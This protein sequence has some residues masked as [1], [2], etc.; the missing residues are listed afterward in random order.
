MRIL[1]AGGNSYTGVHLIQRLETLYS[2]SISKVVITRKPTKLKG[3][4]EIIGDLND[5]N[6]L[7][8]VSGK[9]DC[10][11][12][13]AQSREYRNFPIGYRDMLQI[14]TMFPIFL[15][16]WAINKNVKKFFYFSTGNVYKETSSLL[17]EQSFT[18]PNSFYGASKLSTELFL[19]NYI[20]YFDVINLRIF[21]IYGPG[22]TGML[23]P[24]ILNSIINSKEII[25]ND[26][27]GLKITPI[28]IDDLVNVIIDLV[29]SEQTLPNTINI[30]GDE[31]VSIKDIVDIGSSFLGVSPKLLISN[32]SGKYLMADNSLLRKLV[33]RDF[34]NIKSGINK[35]IQ[36]GRI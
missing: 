6:T 23:I 14:N 33:V 24:S 34:V 5:E 8:K 13:L 3:V 16:N 36:Y 29:I 31:I 35:M 26:G 27:F 28:Y 22:Q 19:K 4:E 21:G 17:D 18:E 30:A 9:V 25:L 15:S 10:I 11:L 20:N 1:I 32:E 2:N 7:N 12:Y